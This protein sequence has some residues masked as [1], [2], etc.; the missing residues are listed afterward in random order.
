MSDDVRAVQRSYPRIWF[1]CHRRHEHRRSSPHRLSARDASLLAH[2]DEERPSAPQELARH[3]GVQPST[4]SA[5]L[6]HLAG[7]GF[8]DRRRADGDGRRQE[9]R[10]TPAGAAVVAEASAL[11]P[12]RVA[13]M[14]A[15]L[16]D[17][18]RRRAVDGLELLAGAALACAEAYAADHETEEEGP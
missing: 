13:A 2:L 1:A 18:E 7:L 3:L 6:G 4:L 14:L 8:V 10:L 17:D 15:R 9:V 12:E 5:A 16:D 11:D